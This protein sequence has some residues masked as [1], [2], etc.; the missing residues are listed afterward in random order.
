MR[1]DSY[2]YVETRSFLSAVIESADT[3]HDFSTFRFWMGAQWGLG[4]SAGLLIM[5]AIFRAV[6]GSIDLDETGHIVDIVRTI[7]LLSCLSFL[8]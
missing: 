3:E 8:G 2:H 1:Y 5:Y 7:I 6:G 4:H